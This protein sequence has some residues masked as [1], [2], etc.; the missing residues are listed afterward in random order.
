MIWHG[1]GDKSLKWKTESRMLSAIGIYLSWQPVNLLV[2]RQ[3]GSHFQH[4]Y[5]H[6]F[7]WKNISFDLNLT[8]V[9]WWQI[10][11]GSTSVSHSWLHNGKQSWALMVS[12]WT[13]MDTYYSI[14]IP[15]SNWSLLMKSYGPQYWLLLLLNHGAL[16]G[17]G[18]LKLHLLI[19]PLGKYSILQ[20]PMLEF[21]NHILIR[22]MSP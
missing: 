16:L 14:V 21:L 13:S 1:I 5:S 11:S 10:I 12:K 22:Q 8:D 2:P 15:Y 6:A 3:N 7:S 20:K 9:C 17:W 18:L 19:S 4:T